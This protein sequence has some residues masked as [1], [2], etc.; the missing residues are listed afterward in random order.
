MWTHTRYPR[1]DG[2]ILESLELTVSQGLTLRVEPLTTIFTIKVVIYEYPRLS[3]FA[4]L[5]TR[6]DNTGL[7]PRD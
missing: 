4:I 2:K 1:A 3:V 5:A 6:R 7:L